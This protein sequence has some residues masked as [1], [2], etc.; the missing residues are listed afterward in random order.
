MSK[1]T[2]PLQDLVVL[3]RVLQQ[4][5][6]AQHKIRLATPVALRLI[7]FPGHH[8]GIVAT[9]ITLVTQTMEVHLTKPTYRVALGIV[10]PN[11]MSQIQR[12]ATE[13]LRPCLIT[14]WT[15]NTDRVRAINVITT[16]MQ[17]SRPTTMAENG[18][19]D[20]IGI[21]TG[22]MT[23]IYHGDKQNLQW[24]SRD[25]ETI[26]PLYTEEPLDLLTMRNLTMKSITKQ[27][28]CFVIVPSY[29]TVSV[30]NERY[31]TPDIKNIRVSPPERYA[32]DDDI[33]MFET[34]L[35]RLLRWF[36]V[37]NVTGNHKDSL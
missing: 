29:V 6:P 3:G 20:P 26:I 11:L 4:K 8:R 28:F 37:Y 30:R 15:M 16:V 23:I 33:E 31:V 17:I 32:G 12:V 10:T 1:I 21:D 7:V 18:I 19:V 2:M 5:T 35:T 24:F 14:T 27:T 9:R 36:R 34:W 13:A 22:M 25:P